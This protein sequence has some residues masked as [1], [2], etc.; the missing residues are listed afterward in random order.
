LWIYSFLNIVVRVVAPCDLIEVYQRLEVV[1]SG[2]IA[3]MIEAAGTCETAVNFYQT[4]R[5]SG[6][7]HNHLHTRRRDSLRHHLLIL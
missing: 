3:L 5:R 4:T 6:P 2:M 7:E 1:A